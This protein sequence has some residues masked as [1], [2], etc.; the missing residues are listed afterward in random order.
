MANLTTVEALAQCIV[1]G[2][3]ESPT[4]WAKAQAENALGH[5]LKLQAA[6]RID[7]G[8][9]KEVFGRL[10]NHSAT[11]QHLEKQGVLKTEADALGNAIKAFMALDA[12]KREETLKNL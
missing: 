11:R 4:S 10:G 7:D 6:K 1:V 8:T 3:G 5:L 12:K 2:L 9:F